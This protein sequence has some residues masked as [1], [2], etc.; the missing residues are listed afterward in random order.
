MNAPWIFFLFCG[1]YAW[2]GYVLG[3]WQRRR[4]RGGAAQE[5]PLQWGSQGPLLEKA[6]EGIS[7]IRWQ[8]RNPRGA[9]EVVGSLQL[10]A[11]EAYATLSERLA[12]TDLQAQ[13]L[14]EEEGE[15]RIL[16]ERRGGEEEEEPAPRGLAV[17]LGLLTLC[18]TAWAGAFH[19]G[20]LFPLEPA[21]AL[22]ALQAALPVW[23]TLLVHDIAHY[24]VAALRGVAL[25]PPYWL[26]APLALGTFGSFLPVRRPGLTR[27]G[28][29]DTAAAGPVAGLF[30][31]LPC[32]YIG[33]K[34]SSFIS[35]AAPP[36]APGVPLRASVGLWALCQLAHGSALSLDQRVLL[37]PL[38]FGGWV[39]VLVTAL[40]LLPVAGLDGGHMAH[41]LWGWKAMRRVSGSTLV[42]L[43]LY[44]FFFW[45]P[46]FAWVLFLALAG[47]ARPSPT[48]NELAPT[49]LF[50]TA[51]AYLLW[52]LAGLIL[53]RLPP[54]LS[55][56][57]SLHS[58]YL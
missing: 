26:P 28:L 46:L 2:V 22:L 29:L 53:L 49:G 25:S 17:I 4:S 51:L 48:G 14:E 34:N 8:G 9:L 47:H 20:V 21:Q 7:T 39:G 42:F 54:S 18:T 12:G 36:F 5:P 6:L 43:L 38:A 40:N 33:L 55:E 16:F 3:A 35:G 50:R 13:L 45:L 23:G 56:L 52:L 37:H 44:A 41:G 11:R 58:P 19:H 27:G 31:C 24:A 57:W 30:V 10:P 15:V 32:L 1:L